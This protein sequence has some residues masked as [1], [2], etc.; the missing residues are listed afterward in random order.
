MDSLTEY[1]DTQLIPLDAAL[2]KQA[3]DLEKV[4][5]EENYC[6]RIMARGFA[7]ELNKIA[8]DMMGYGTGAGNKQQQ[9]PPAAPVAPA[10]PAPTK[11]APDFGGSVGLKPRGIK[12][13]SVP[14]IPEG[15]G[16]FGKGSTIGVA[17]QIKGPKP[18]VPP[19]Q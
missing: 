19:A 3:A 15:K 14:S 8:N 12:A 13:P 11:L 1:Y 9:K 10:R 5:A 7:D 2:E 6:G 16:K 18:V 4:A 17:G